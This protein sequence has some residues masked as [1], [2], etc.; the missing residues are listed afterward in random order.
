MSAQVANNIKAANF[1]LVNIGRA[2]K[3]LTTNAIKL[4]V[5]TLHLVWTTATICSSA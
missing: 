2:R 3:L 1:Q 4:A 5:H